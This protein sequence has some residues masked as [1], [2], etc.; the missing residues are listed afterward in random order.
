MVL[1]YNFLLRLYFVLV[2]IASVRNDKAKKFINGR[3]RIFRKIRKEIDVNAPKIWVHCASLGEFEQGRPVIEAY[4]KQHPEVKVVLT[5]F[6]PSGYEVR[7]N[8]AGA[9]YIYYLPLDTYFNAK[10][11]VSIINPKAAIF[12]KYEFWYHYLKT[13]HKN[14]VPTYVISAIFRPNQVFFKWY[15]GLFRGMLKNYKQ[16]FVQNQK[17]KDLLSTIN[18]HNVTISGDT[19]FDRV[20]E[21]AANAK[22][23]PVVESFAKNNFVVVGG[24][25]WAP[26]EDLLVEFVKKHQDVKMIIA[27]HETHE[28]HIVEIMGKL[29]GVPSIR[30]TEAT[31]ENVANYRVLVI[32]VIG[33]LSSVY[34]YGKVGYIGGGFGV[35]I[36]N[37]LEAAT[38][39]LPVLFGPNYQ[40][41]QEAKDLVATGGAFPITN[42]DEVNSAIE[43]LHSNPEKLAQSSGAA[44]SYVASQVGATAAILAQVE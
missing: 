17:S 37:T 24:S 25:T 36:H 8:Y 18:V 32:D 10:K 41:F 31:P 26:D 19:R 39:G 22:S 38:F 3:K 7:K 2:L 28:S 6:S 33:I 40:K 12:V 29:Q 42:Y 20:A 34:Q 30:Y 43:M 16:I 35:G 15:G 13:L 1:L 9:D 44:K 27:A 5:F 4:K 21:I 23:L 14:H 11:F